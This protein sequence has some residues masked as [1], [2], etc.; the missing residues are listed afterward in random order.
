MP[1]A[2][3]AVHKRLYAFT[4]AVT[5]SIIKR[6]PRDSRSF[7]LYTDPFDSGSYMKFY[8]LQHRLEAK[9]MSMVHL[10]KL[11]NVFNAMQG[12]TE[13]T[14]LFLEDCHIRGSA[15]FWMMSEHLHSLVLKNVRVSEGNLFAASG[16]ISTPETPAWWED[17]IPVFVHQ[18]HLSYCHLEGLEDY[19]SS[20]SAERSR[21]L[22]FHAESHEKIDQGLR[23]LYWDLCWHTWCSDPME[24]SLAELHQELRTT[25]T[26]HYQTKERDDRIAA[27]LPPER[28]AA[29]S[30]A[31][32]ARQ[33]SHSLH[34][35]ARKQ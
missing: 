34:T 33:D 26:A 31:L 29:K 19:T 20:Q 12:G 23:K 16:E 21:A 32:S 2:P 13:V 10:D 14:E 18:A 27:I 4:A 3:L 17:I 9:G 6:P 25:R 22:A 7:I 11:R 8:P 35:N 24:Q 15:F 5:A 28:G 1:P 30:S